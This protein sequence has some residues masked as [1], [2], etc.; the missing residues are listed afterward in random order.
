MAD[1]DDKTEEPTSKRLSDAR[2]KGQVVSSP[3]VKTFVILL[4]GLITISYFLPSSMVRIADTLQRFLAMP[5]QV[6]PDAASLGDFIASSLMQILL[7]LVIPF[8]FMMIM[9]VASGMIQT[10]PLYAPEAIKVNWNKL[11][12]LE[13]F[14]RMFSMNALIEL[15]KSTLKVIIVGS[16]GYTVIM[17]ALRQSDLLPGMSVIDILKTTKDLVVNMMSAVLATVAIIAA[18]D[19]IQKRM[20]FMKSMRMSKEEVKDESKQSEGD[21]KVKA[22]LRQLRMQKAR[23]RMM[24]AVPKADVVITNPTHYAV[25]LEYKPETMNAPVVVAM[26]AD[27]VALKIKEIANENKVAIVSNPPLARA[28]FDTAEL[29]QPIPVEQYQAVAE[30]ISYVFRLRGRKVGK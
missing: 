14:K 25:A 15:A 28:L 21:P 30:V 7:T 22:R 6:G 5:D 8:L 12:P 29:E 24:S 16:V 13:G 19:Y 11:N 4:G 23:Q 9:A 1:T 26:G 17:K 20:A 10:G 2:A 27:L 3:E 18:L